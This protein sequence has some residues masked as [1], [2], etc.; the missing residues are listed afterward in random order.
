[1]LGEKVL[2][3]AAIALDHN[4]PIIRSDGTIAGQTR[5]VPQPVIDNLCKATD[6]HMRALHDGTGET[7]SAAGSQAER[8]EFRGISVAG[9]HQFI[10]KAA[11]VLYAKQHPL[12]V[13]RGMGGNDEVESGRHWSRVR[14]LR[15]VSTRRR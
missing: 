5:E 14:S 12:Q 9:N 11:G 13:Q 15:D 4:N 10:W 8:A 2:A 6:S 7:E 1:V 3:E